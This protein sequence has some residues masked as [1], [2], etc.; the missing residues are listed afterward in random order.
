MAKVNLICL[1]RTACSSL[2]Y[3][4][5]NVLCRM[6]PLCN[7]VGMLYMLCSRDRSGITITQSRAVHVITKTQCRPLC[8]TT[9][10]SLKRQIERDS[11]LLS[12]DSRTHSLLHSTVNAI[13]Y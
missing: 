13:L 1:A 10:L 9:I 7:N 4:K 2:R 5:M 3:R 6:L 11:C 12:Y 8:S